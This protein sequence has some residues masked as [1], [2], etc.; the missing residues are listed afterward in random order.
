MRVNFCKWTAL[1]LAAACVCAFCGCNNEGD[2]D[3]Y[4]GIVISQEQPH[5]KTT[6]AKA[7]SVIF[8]ML[9]HASVLQS[10]KVYEKL[11]KIAK[12]VQAVMANT[13]IHE[14]LYLALIEKL[15]TDGGAV[16]DELASKGKNGLTAT[17]SMYLDLSSMVGV[18][19]VGSVLY[20][21]GV[22]FLQ[23]QY[24]QN[25]EKYNKY[26]YNYLKLDAEK[27]QADKQTLESGIGKENFITVLKS[28]F[29]FADLFF[30]DGM[31]SEQFNTFTDTEIL[32]FVQGLDLSSLSMTEAG[33][34][35]VFSRAVPDDRGMYAL[36]LL[37][38]VKEHDLTEGA[39]VLECAV[40]LLSNSINRWT[41]TDAALLRAGD[42]SAMIRLAFERFDE[43][44]WILFERMAT[45]NF[46]LEQYD[47]LAVETYGEAY[48][49]YKENLTAYTM[50]DLRD[51]VGQ[52][53]FDEV[54]QGYIAGIFPAI[55]YGENND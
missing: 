48:L 40:K 10:D 37:N 54:L 8:S 35:L 14:E 29:A 17:K 36:K 30:G 43:A 5:S 52:E 7:E 9:Q 55:A 11:R 39:K 41:E 24:E 21:I 4:S 20:D 16:I 27:Y 31:N 25:I 26:G 45:Q 53:N 38:A 44:D 28:G 3:S 32:T 23:Y 34:Q 6:A 13:P 2:E 46:E 22:Y 1:L 51:A 33:W 50:A 15:E 47:T 12:D 49:Q 42:I 19:Y 18:E